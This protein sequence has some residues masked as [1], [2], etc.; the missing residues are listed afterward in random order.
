[1]RIIK[2]MP[3]ELRGKQNALIGVFDD[4][5]MALAV[6]R[7]VLRRARA[8]TSL[9]LQQRDGDGRLLEEWVVA[10]RLEPGK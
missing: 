2:A 8:D 9:V 10:R 6:A 1:M 4:R 7:E 5:T 3:F